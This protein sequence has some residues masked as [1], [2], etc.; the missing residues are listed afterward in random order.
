M[1]T[2]RVQA[3]VDDLTRAARE[4]FVGVPVTEPGSGRTVGRV[5]RASCD[6][7]GIIR[8]A[9]DLDAGPIADLLRDPRHAF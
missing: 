4:D 3:T 5:V 2:I 9:F 1:N 7:D 8:V 6:A